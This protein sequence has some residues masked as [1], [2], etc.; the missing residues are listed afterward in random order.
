VTQAAEHGGPMI[1][2][3]MGMMQ[4]IHRHHKRDFNPD[5]KDHRSSG[6]CDS[7]PPERIPAS[8]SCIQGSVAELRRVLGCASIAAGCITD[9]ALFGRYQHTSISIS[10]S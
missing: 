6:P 10:A 9:R 3:Q 7:G 2:A 1:F 5:R 8:F 4:A